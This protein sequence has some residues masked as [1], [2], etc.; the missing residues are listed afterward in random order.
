MANIVNTSLDMIRRHKNRQP[1]LHARWGDVAIT[2]PMEGAWSQLHNPFLQEHIEYGPGF[3]PGIEIGD[4][5]VLLLDS[6]T[7]ISDDEIYINEKMHLK[8]EK[9]D[10]DTESRAVSKA[11]RLT[12]ILLPSNVNSPLKKGAEKDKAGE[13]QYRP[14]QPDYAQEIAE[15]MDKQKKP[16][17]RYVPASKHYLRELKGETGNTHHR[18][19]HHHHNETDD[20]AD[21]ENDDQAS[22]KSARRPQQ[23][24]SQS[25]DP[26]LGSHSAIVTTRRKPRSQQSATP[27]KIHT[28]SSIASLSEGR[29]SST[30]S[31]KSSSRAS[32]TSRRG[33]PTNELKYNELDRARKQYIRPDTIALPAAVRRSQSAIN[34]SHRRTMTLEMVRDQDD[35]W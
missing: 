11:R 17:F 13:F 6:E 20:D 33:Q 19:H 12:R 27:E 34:K 4:K 24:R 30:V 16:N 32:N 22:Y 35:L 5:E 18:H 9:K 1:R 28:P 10:K 21:D 31:R 15:K 3:V 29:T 7:D 8:D 14:V 2:A 23:L 25:C 26:H